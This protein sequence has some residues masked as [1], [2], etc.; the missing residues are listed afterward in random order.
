MGKLA[1]P[2]GFIDEGETVEE[3]LRR[4]VREEVGLSLKRLEFLTS[5]PN[6]YRYREV[7]YPVL[8]LFFTAEADSEV[9][10]PDLHEVASAEWLNPADVSPDDMA[11]V[12]TRA[13]FIEY[14]RR[15]GH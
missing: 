11:F 7:V 3:A 10:S 4:E 12:S 6:S 13:A 9:V 2:G 1:P 15:A 5:R 8:D 14:L